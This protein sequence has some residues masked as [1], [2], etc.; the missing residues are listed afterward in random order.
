MVRPIRVLWTANIVL[1]V[2]ARLLGLDETPFGGWLSVTTQRLAQ[3]KDLQIGIAM[4]APIVRLQRLEHDGIIYFALPQRRTDIYDVAQSDCDRVLDD[5]APDILH[6]EGTE[7]RYTQRLMESWRGPRLVS[8]QG[9]INGYA[10]HQFGGLGPGDFLNWRRPRHALVGAALLGNDRLRF[11]PRLE[12]ERQTIALADHILG[13]TIWDRAQAAWLNPEARYHHCP[14]ILRDAFYGR[15]WESGQ[16]EP[17]TIFVGNGASALKGVH[18]V[19]RA[20]ARLRHRYPRLRLVI[21]GRDPNT[22]S[23]FSAQRLVG[24]SAWLRDLIVDQDMAGHVEFTGQLDAVQMADR[25]C[26]SHIF[27][28]PSL[29][30]NS[31]NTLAEAMLMGVPSVSAYTGGVPSMAADEREVLM[32]RAEDP[33][34]L[35]YQIG[36]LFDDPALCRRLSEA[37]RTRARGVHDPEAII[38]TLVGIYRHIE[39]ESAGRWVTGA[40]TQALS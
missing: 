14:R 37:A 26:R 22:L 2:A 23:P 28:L 19:V 20:A 18:F 38:D 33:A 10:A 24:Y 36:R 34:M 31:P 11:R 4:R 25:M 3:R 12:P 32:Y 30:E 8:L 39:A 6:A 35:A 15:A 1:P 40:Q 7:M 17:F 29:I 13:R 5:F 16:H 27:V 9:V 21:A